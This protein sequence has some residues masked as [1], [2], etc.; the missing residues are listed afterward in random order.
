MT[1]RH[2][3]FEVDGLPLD[4]DVDPGQVLRTVLREHGVVAD[5]PL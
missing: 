5:P 1:P 4:A 3:T 2:V